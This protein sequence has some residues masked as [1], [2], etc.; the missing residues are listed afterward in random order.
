MPLDGLP[1]KRPYRRHAATARLPGE[2]ARARSERLDMRI[3]RTSLSLNK[4]EWRRYQDFARIQ[5]KTPGA[6]LRDLV[7]GEVAEY[8]EGL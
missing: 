8:E 7:M 5:G 2:S 6:L 3:T 4:D 1:D